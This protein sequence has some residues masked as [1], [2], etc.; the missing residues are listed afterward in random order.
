MTLPAF[1]TFRRRSL[2]RA[3]IAATNVGLLFGSV[4]AQ[5][6]R[7]RERIAEAMPRLPAIDAVTKT[8]IP[9]IYELRIGNEI[10]YTDS[11]G[12]Y[13]IDGS[14]TEAKTHSNLTDARIAQW[15]KIQY[16]ELAPWGSL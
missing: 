15:T 1:L 14:I 2:M 4:Q 9:G 8:P 6:A 16:G 10:L 7:I 11:T 5:E 13:I 12:T 3:L